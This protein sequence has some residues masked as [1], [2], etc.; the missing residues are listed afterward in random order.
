M[1]D[2]LASAE[3][4]SRNNNTIPGKRTRTLRKKDSSICINLTSHLWTISQPANL[5]LHLVNNLFQFFCSKIAKKL[6][7]PKSFQNE[8]TTTTTA[9]PLHYN[10]LRIGRSP[11]FGQFWSRHLWQPHI[12]T[13]SALNLFAINTMR[14]FNSEAYTKWQNMGRKWHG[15]SDCILMI[16]FQMRMLNRWALALKQ[17]NN[18]KVANK[19]RFKAQYEHI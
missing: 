16:F 4:K 3:F 8:T 6:F 18:C 17:S 14:F 13:V 10:N 9:L 5:H 11:N 2:F 12:L 19:S 1:N 7:K 15:P